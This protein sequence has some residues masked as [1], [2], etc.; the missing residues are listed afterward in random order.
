MR[1][2]ETFLNGLRDEREVWYRGE[3]VDDVVEHAEGS[4]EAEKLML[5]RSYDPGPALDFVRRLTGIAPQAVKEVTTQT[6]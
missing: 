2:G 6:S 5:H 4:L 1:D 3:R